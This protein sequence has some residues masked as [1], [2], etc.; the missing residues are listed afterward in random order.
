MTGSAVQS[1]RVG[2]DSDLPVAVKAS[3][4]LEERSAMEVWLV[5]GLA[6]GAEAELV[7]MKILDS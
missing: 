3:C 5:L 4:Q 2:C 1:V 6:V 7:K